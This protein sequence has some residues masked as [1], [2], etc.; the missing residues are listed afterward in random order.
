MKTWKYIFGVL[1]LITSVLLVAIFSFPDKKL[2]L[3]AC[4]VGE[5]DAILAVYGNT[6]ILFD[7]G[8]DNKVLD[9]LSSYLPFWDREIELV[10]LTH[11][12]SD[13]YTGLIEV[14]RRYKI[15]NFL[16]NKLENSSQGYQMLVKEVGGS[17]SRVFFP[18][19]GMKL[20]IGSIYLDILWP[21]DT[22]EV[23]LEISANESSNKF[24][25]VTNLSLGNFDALITG[26]IDPVSEDRLVA[27]GSIK[28]VE[29][30]KVPHHGSKNGLTQRLLETVMP[31]LAIISVGKN[32]W[33]HPHQEILG[34][35]EGKN[36][37]TLRTDLNG[38]IEIITD[39]KIWWVKK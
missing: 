32:P 30:I 37:K 36:V 34:M 25:I 16:A 38:N 24:S 11:P 3:I 27:A 7:G 17:N 22:L 10:V 2:H 26:D 33:G 23:P 14:F 12:D 9:C 1:I 19:Q 8:P 18:K 21:L 15:D 5:G 29:Y 20:G 13:H 4:N 6:Q 31:K 35:L 39:G 28:E